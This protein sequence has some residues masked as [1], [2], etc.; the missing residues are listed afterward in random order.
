MERSPC[1]KLQLTTAFHAQW[2]GSSRFPI[3]SLIFDIL[4]SG[5]LAISASMNFK[6][7]RSIALVSF[8][9]PYIVNAGTTVTC[10]GTYTTLEENCFKAISTVL[11]RRTGCD[12][13]TWVPGTM[14]YTQFGECVAEIVN[15]RNGRTHSPGLMTSSFYRMYQLCDAGSGQWEYDDDNTIGRIYSNGQKRSIDVG[16]NGTLPGPFHFDADPWD[17]PDLRKEWLEECATVP[18]NTTKIP[19]P[20]KRRL[21]KRMCGGTG[22]F[23]SGRCILRRVR[24]EILPDRV[25]RPYDVGVTFLTDKIFKDI[26]AGK[27][28]LTMKVQVAF[29]GDNRGR[30]IATADWRQYSDDYNNI[31]SWGEFAYHIGGTNGIDL[32]RVLYAAIR[33]AQ[34]IVAYN[35]LYTIADA[36]NYFGEFKFVVTNEGDWIP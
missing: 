32:Y 19:Q 18:S 28:D 2:K 13:Y 31:A 12:G 22:I 36:D 5:S 1:W 3:V 11:A 6:A 23:T 17:D 10:F 9:L 25:Y 24:T 29:D 26:M 14:E 33:D 7:L 30:S 27:S 16:A 34:Q 35:V 15:H 20:S 4:P 8:T 21:Q